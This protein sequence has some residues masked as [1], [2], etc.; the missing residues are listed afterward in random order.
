MRR[1]LTARFAFGVTLLAA[2][3]QPAFAQLQLPSTGIGSG[4]APGVGYGLITIGN[5]GPYITTDLKVGHAPAPGATSP[6]TP[7]PGA[8]PVLGPH[9]ALVLVRDSKGVPAFKAMAGKGATIPTLVIRSAHHLNTFTNVTIV[10]ANDAFGSATAAVP[11]ANV[12]LH[13]GTFTTQTIAAP[14]EP[15]PTATPFTFHN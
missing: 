1:S 12:L 15:T 10:S 8:L 13:F 14:G 11:I 5:E 2:V 4:L 9:D 6:P 7:A 3:G